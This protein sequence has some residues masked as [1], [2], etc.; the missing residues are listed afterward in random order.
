MA[1]KT[2]NVT[3]EASDA[4]ERDPL[5]ISRAQLEAL[6]PDEQNAFRAAGGTVTENLN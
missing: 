6:T 3:D 5:I 4:T 2:T 1:K